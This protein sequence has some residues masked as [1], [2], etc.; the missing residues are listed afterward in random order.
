AQHGYLLLQQS[1]A[2]SIAAHGSSGMGE[3]RVSVGEIHED[4]TSLPVAIANYVRRTQEALLLSNAWE[5]P[6]FSSDEKVQSVRPKSV[7]C[8]PTSPR[9]EILG[10]LYLQN[11]LTAEAFPPSCLDVL[12]VLLAQAAISLETAR[13]Y[14]EMQQEVAERKRA[15]ASLQ[16]AY[17]SLE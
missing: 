2:L 11:A 1:G 12:Q 13:V 17:D 14:E 5:D 15:E 10:L 9:R 16:Q 4:E 6:R 8:P 7:L 3:M